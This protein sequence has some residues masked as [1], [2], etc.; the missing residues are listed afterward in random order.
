MLKRKFLETIG[1]GIEDPLFQQMWKKIN[2]ERIFLMHKFFNVFPVAELKG[3]EAAA[4]RLARIDKLLDVGR[5]LLK[6]AL[7]LTFDRFNIEPAKRREFLAFVV[8]HR[9]KSK[10]SV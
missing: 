1:K 4:T 7:D 6:T 3:N 2:Q 8:D 9:K 10:I 5:R